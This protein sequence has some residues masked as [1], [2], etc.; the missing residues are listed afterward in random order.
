MMENH[1]YDNKLGMLRRPGADGFRLGRDGLPLATNPYA[2]GDI[3]HAF[4]MPTTCQLDGAP[5]QDWLDSHIQFDGGRN[6][7]FVE[8]GSGP[9]AMGYWEQA[10]QPFYYS[11]ASAF[12]IVGPVLLLGARPDLPE[13][14]VPDG[15]HLDRPGERHHA[16]AHRLPAERHHLRPAAT[17]RASPGGTTT[18]TWPR[19]SCTP[20]CT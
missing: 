10:D 6:D 8:S 20:S 14:A 5:G 11:L 12:P 19:S 7:G 18:P 2:N 16:R 4:R 1:S 13:P 9:V 17:R 3:Q 15:G